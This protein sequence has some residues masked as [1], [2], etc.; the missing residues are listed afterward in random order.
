MKK[1][2]YVL[3]ISLSL[4]LAGCNANPSASTAPAEPV[5]SAATPLTASGSLEAENVTLASDVGATI[6]SITVDQGQAAQTGQVLVILDDTLAQ[7]Q[8]AQA[9]AALAVTQAELTQTLTG[10]RANVVAAAEADLSHAQAQY[11]GALRAVADTAALM[12]NPPGLDTQIAQA[13]MQVKLAEQ[14]IQQSKS[15]EAPAETLRDTYP[16]GWPERDLYQQKMDAANASLEAAKY[17]YD[18]AV[19]AL[20]Q[21]RSMRKFPA[22]LVAQWHAAQ[23]QAIVAAA[24]VTVTKT[25]LTLAQTGATVEQVAIAEAQVQIAQANLDLVDEQLKHYQIS[26][27]ISGVVTSK[28]A[29]AGEVAVAGQPLLVLS[30]LN[31]M[32]LVV[33]IPVT[34]M[35][36]VAVGAPA[37]VTVNA[38]PAETFTG[39]VSRIGSKAEYTPSNVQSKEDRSKL[40]FAVTVT[41]PNPQ[42]RLKAGMPA[43][44]HIGD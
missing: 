9:E 8:H 3:L 43:D 23:S 19:A 20:D 22:E 16:A 10:P 38:Y 5:P 25:A 42:M 1:R 18:G 41:I 27:P 24:Q 4:A 40:V 29:L 2:I 28:P 30:D 36:H 7:A 33:Y 44:V 31:Q 12:A 37:K 17:Q 13:E 6:V 32:K 11:T 15:V 35:S 34:Q 14:A 26:A 21:L 39:A